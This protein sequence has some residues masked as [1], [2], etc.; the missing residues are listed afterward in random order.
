MTVCFF[1]GIVIFFC[2]WFNA[3]YRN[4]TNPSNSNPSFCARKET[5]EIR[6][7]FILFSAFLKV[8][9]ETFS[10]AEGETIKK[11]RPV[12]GLFPD[13]RTRK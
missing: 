11:Q 4:K 12:S 3:V 6:V 7:S 10:I 8:K 5:L 13:Q 9:F 1:L 2:N